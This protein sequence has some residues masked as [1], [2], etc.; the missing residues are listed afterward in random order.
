[1]K[2]KLFSKKKISTFTKL[3]I[4]LLFFILIL[5]LCIYI[6]YQQKKYFTVNENI[7]K[8]YI[9]PT[10]KEGEKVNYLNIK[11]ININNALSNN[12][13]LTDI[14]NIKFTIQLYSDD[15]LKMVKKY[16]DKLKRNKIEIIDEKDLFVFLINTDLGPNYFVSYKNFDN[17]IKALEYC[18]NLSFLN[19]CL[20][21][22]LESYNY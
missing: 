17:K 7:N 6:F 12:N 16:L 15:N 21:I 19:K 8:Y 4:F 13:E 2:K 18:E 9:I 3:F 11:S 14:Q 1:M 5:Y 20:I 10:D 22:N